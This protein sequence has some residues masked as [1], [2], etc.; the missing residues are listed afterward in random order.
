LFGDDPEM[1]SSIRGIINTGYRRGGV[2]SRI[3]GMGTN[4]EPKDFAVFCPKAFAGIGNRLPD[5][6]ADRSIPIVLKR[7]SPTEREPDRFRQAR[8]A[9]EL[10]SLAMQ[11]RGWGRLHGKSIGAS[12]PLMPDGL[13][14]RQQDGWEPLFAIAA[15]A[16]GDW[17]QRVEQAALALHEAAEDGDLAMHLLAHVRDAFDDNGDRLTTFQLLEHLVNRGDASPWAHWWSEDLEKGGAHVKKAAQGLARKL[18]PLGIKP[19]QIRFGEKNY[20]GYEREKF[21]DSWERYLPRSVPDD[22]EVATSLPSRSGGVFGMDS[23]EPES[24]SDQDCSDVA[25]GN[26]VEPLRD[27]FD[28]LDS[29]FWSTPDADAY[30]A[31]HEAEDVEP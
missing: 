3:V 12:E 11:L 23:S 13:S 22:S 14:D 16:G 9:A 20:R 24:A 10:A 28:D 6:V 29:A 4:L 17:P 5:T 30:L 19:S 31:S 15:L 18:Q 21:E 2:I 25:T 1:T 7:R 27:V 8:A 26:P